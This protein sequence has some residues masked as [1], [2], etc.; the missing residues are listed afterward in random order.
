MYVCQEYK[1]VAPV[2]SITREGYGEIRWN[3]TFELPSLDEIRLVRI[4]DGFVEVP[5]GSSLDRPAS[6]EMKCKSNDLFNLLSLQEVHDLTLDGD[7]V[8]FSVIHFSRYGLGRFVPEPKKRRTDIEE[9]E[10]ESVMYRPISRIPT[11]VRQDLPEPSPNSLRFSSRFCPNLIQRPCH[12]SFKIEI[13]ERTLQRRELLNFLVYAFKRGK[14]FVKDDEN[15]KK[16][17]EATELVQILT[18]PTVDT[19]SALID[20]LMDN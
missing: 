13:D 18:D 16:A 2:L 14:D 15:V 6:V 12:F 17:Q 8:R 19:S 10:E 5:T 9:E 11:E 1:F 3:D 4:G 7:I 20:F